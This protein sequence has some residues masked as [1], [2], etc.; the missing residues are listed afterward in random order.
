MWTPRI[1]GGA[2]CTFDTGSVDGVGYFWG[3]DDP[4]PTKLVKG[5]AGEG[6]NPLTATIV[7]N[8]G[9]HTLYVAAVDRGGNISAVTE[10]PFNVGYGSLNSPADGDAIAS[11]ADGESTGR[12]LTLESVAPS[13]KY[14]VTYRYKAIDTDTWTAVPVGDVTT[15]TGGAPASWP[16][17]RTD[18]AAPVPSLSWNAAKTAKDAGLTAGGFQVVACFTDKTTGNEQCSGMSTIAV[19]DPGVPEDTDWTPLP[20]A[21][22]Q[23]LSA[24]GAGDFDEDC[25]VGSRLTSGSGSTRGRQAGS[26]CAT[27]VDL[28]NVAVQGA[29]SSARQPLGPGRPSGPTKGADGSSTVTWTRTRDAVPCGGLPSVGDHAVGKRAYRAGRAL[30]R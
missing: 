6:D 11:S 21:T 12:P 22:C 15:A 14:G 26:A 20:A 3:L 16:L 28:R 7:P 23:E 18:T 13:D 24:S 25:G 19:K 5:S 1:S 8:Y 10:Y 4:D 17:K 27:V 29:V 2:P 9:P 30:R